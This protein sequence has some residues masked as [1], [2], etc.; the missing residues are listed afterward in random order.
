MRCADWM[1]NFLILG[2]I[3]A[4]LPEKADG[5]FKDGRNKTVILSQTTHKAVE[6]ETRSIAEVNSTYQQS[7]DGSFVGS[8]S[9][10]NLEGGN[11]SLENVDNII[12]TLS[13]NTTASRFGANFTHIFL[14]GSLARLVRRQT[15]RD[16]TA[17]GDGMKNALWQNSAINETHIGSGISLNGGEKIKEPHVSSV[18]SEKTPTR[19]ETHSENGVSLIGNEKNKE[20]FISSVSSEETSTETLAP[21]SSSTI[22]PLE[23][24]FHS[25]EA[26][27]IVSVA[28][29][30]IACQVILCMMTRT[31][32]RYV[33]CCERLLTTFEPD[34]EDE[35]SLFGEDDN[36]ERSKRK[37]S[38]T[39]WNSDHL[40][41]IDYFD[42]LSETKNVD[43][44]ESAD[45]SRRPSN[46]TLGSKS[47]K[48]GLKGLKGLFRQ[49]SV[50][51]QDSF[52]VDN[53]R[54]QSGDSLGDGS[55]SILRTSSGDS[56][57]KRP[58]DILRF[59]GNSLAQ[60]K[61][62][63]RKV[64]INTSRRSSS[65]S[66]DGRPV[67]FSSRSTC[68][69]YERQVSGE[70]FDGGLRG[71]LRRSSGDS[72]SRRLSGD[73]LGDGPMGI[74]RRASGDS[75]DGVP[76]RLTR[77]KL[78][79]SVMWKSSDGVHIEGDRVEDS[80][81]SSND[82]MEGNLSDQGAPNQK[83]I[84]PPKRRISLE[85]K[86]A[87]RLLESIV[88]IHDEV[89]RSPS[90]SY[91]EHHQSHSAGLKV[92]RVFTEDVTVV[93]LH[94]DGI[95]T[96]DNII[97]VPTD[98]LPTLQQFSVCTRFRLEHYSAMSSFVSYYAD[99]E[100]NEIYFGYKHE[101]VISVFCCHSVVALHVETP[102][103]PAQLLKWNDICLAVDLKA[104][105]YFMMMNG[106][107]WNAT[108][109][110]KQKNSDTEVVKVIGGGRL[111][112]GND[113]DSLEGDFAID[114]AMK[115]EL[116]NYLFY[117]SILT[118]QN[119]MDYATCQTKIEGLEPLYQF[120]GSWPVLELK[121]KTSRYTASI[122]SVCPKVRSRHATVHFP[123]KM[124]FLEAN[125]W[126][127]ILKGSLE[128]P[129]NEEEHGKSAELA[130]RFMKQCTFGAGIYWL[131]ISRDHSGEAWR[132]LSNKENLTWDKL[133]PPSKSTDAYTCAVVLSPVFKNNW[134]PVPCDD[135]ICPI[136]RFTGH[137][138]LRMRGLCKASKFD[139]IYTIKNGKGGTPEFLGH[140]LTVIRLV[141][142]NWYMNMTSNE[143]GVY[144]VT[145]PGPL[146]G[147]P[148]GRRLWT[149]E[150]D[151]CQVD[152]IE[153]TLLFTLC[154]GN[155][156]T[157]DDGSCIPRQQRC[158]QKTQCGD[159]SDEKDC[160]VIIPPSSYSSDI[161]P[162]ASRESPL[163]ISFMQEIISVK[164]MNIAEFRVEIDVCETLKWKDFRLR[165]RNLEV[166][167]FTNRVK[168]SEV[169]WIPEFNVQSEDRTLASTTTKS[170]V[171]FV[172][173]DSNPLQENDTSTIE[174]EIFEGDRNTLVLMTCY[175]LAFSCQFNLRRYP[176]DTQFCSVIF[177]G[178][179]FNT[180]LKY[181]IDSVDFIGN[182]RLLEYEI[183]NVTSEIVKIN[184]EMAIKVG[185]E[186]KNQY[187]F[188]IGNAF[189]PSGLLIIIC[190]LTFLFDL[191]DFQDRIMVSLT[192]LLVLTGLLTQTNQAVPHTAYMKYID[193]WYA[194]LIIF[195][196]CMVVTLVVVEV[197]R[198]RGKNKVDT[199]LH[200]KVGSRKPLRM[201]EVSSNSWRFPKHI[202]SMKLFQSLMEMDRDF[203]INRGAIFFFPAVGLTFQI[204][205]ISLALSFI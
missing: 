29:V 192:S 70:S 197:Y 161:P 120:S 65:D 72:Y 143:T 142:R 4:A 68:D 200:M 186:F 1:L 135:R 162:P 182:R 124:G 81:E 76:A 115:G 156:Y 19:S 90:G 107:I 187:A 121:G 74:L 159:L 67:D 8:S 41:M 23:D 17:A 89:T 189:I 98:A 138:T 136:C 191:D 10:L 193:V 180:N 163:E 126:C 113:M 125:R 27:L 157:C 194:C 18:L 150:G 12:P 36:G 35:D 88:E 179:Q 109:P 199:I 46:D 172:Q 176:F 45:S 129:E 92:D 174:D 108:I 122:E 100:A 204:L 185:L 20:P 139:K 30:C 64:S 145:D 133:I 87:S 25:W 152:K 91:C 26:I 9:V 69:C 153:Q 28:A 167:N 37:S 84:V 97:D 151:E 168:P 137:P 77:N 205:F 140:F 55:V 16:S 56:L 166:G 62:R 155:E 43:G 13:P 52:S 93:D 184:R 95:I 48:E 83:S 31:R 54:R 188:Y 117:D 127:S 82:S 59:S 170:S 144:A 132:K 114:Q 131:G 130:G 42:Y 57:D 196:F 80:P 134:S 164:E 105:H 50:D 7:P 94:S 85:H 73:S 6:R 201:F 2:I 149:I 158:D 3:K 71:I 102:G 146:Y 148:I 128:V 63:K 39:S 177:L 103:P 104:R 190:Y 198:L 99:G 141:N 79:D 118:P 34:K 21:M 173:R 86:G 5:F 75:L 147:Y 24:F 111:V 169:P 154:L 165:F 181:I 183:T 15:V 195:D 112:I 96:L 47:P 178:N 119:L 116:A 32:L 60:N 171:L 38:G 40:K 58:V 101:G 11:K 66:L 53:E 110:V 78:G 44:M 106:K 51:S 14:E 203:L 61:R 175:T 33:T 160:S 123:Y 49:Q 22:S 202:S